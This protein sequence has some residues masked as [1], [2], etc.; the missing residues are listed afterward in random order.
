ESDFF[1]RFP[2]DT[3]AAISTGSQIAAIGVLRLSG[4]EAFAVADVVFRS[5]DGRP[6]S[7]H[8]RRAMVFG[9]LLDG[10]GA[11]MDQILAVSFAAGASYTGEDSVEF[12]CHGSPV[13]LQ[14]G[15]RALFAAGARQAA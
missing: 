13:V 6:L 4:P 11:P 1:R 5:A 14:E 2:M 7:A 9:T 10:H 3:I 15:L 8:P 12:H